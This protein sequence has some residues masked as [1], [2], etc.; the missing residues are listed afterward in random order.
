MLQDARKISKSYF[1]KVLL[2]VTLPTAPVLEGSL[3]FEAGRG[4]K[5]GFL[6]LISSGPMWSNV[7]P[8]W[9]LPRHP[10]WSNV[11]QNLK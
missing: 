11:P 4:K 9:P 2:V 6:N 5:E 8:M 1:E 10:K 3:D 7:G